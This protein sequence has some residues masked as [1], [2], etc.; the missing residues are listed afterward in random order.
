[1]EKQTKRFEDWIE[2]DC[3]ECTHWW[4]NSC[5]GAKYPLERPRTPC[6]SFLATRSVIIP[7]QI[8][9]LLRANKRLWWALA[10]LACWNLGIS[11]GRLL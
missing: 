11:I 10:I 7:E 8:K 6:N 9:T 1:M 3:N 2:V 5:D 4:D